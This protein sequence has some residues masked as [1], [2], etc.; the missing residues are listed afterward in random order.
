M[1]IKKAQELMKEIEFFGGKDFDKKEECDLTDEGELTA[2][3]KSAKKQQMLEDAK[4]ELD[5]CN[6]LPSG[7]QS[8]TSL[9]FKK[10]IKERIKEL[11]EIIKCLEKMK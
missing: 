4:D 3:L 10:R 6:S 1:Q 8:K 11:K 2:T 7:P 5:F 9:Y